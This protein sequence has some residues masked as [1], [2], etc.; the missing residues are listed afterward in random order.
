M[1]DFMISQIQD[2]SGIGLFCLIAVFFY[3]GLITIGGGQVAITVMQ[4]VLV[5]QFHLIDD[6]FFFNMVAISESTP[7]PIGIN[8]ATY[9]GTELYGVWGGFFSTLGEVL[10]SLICIV[11]I[12]KF[13]G[14][15]AEKKGVKA[16][17]STLRPAVSGVI[18][19][20]AARIIIIALFVVREGFLLSS[21]STWN[22][23]L[24]IYG[25]SAIFYCLCLSVLF[26]TK[27]HPVF[28]VAAGALFGAIF[29]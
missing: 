23:N 26:R 12:A 7:G 11:L 4:Q 18:A 10:P 16:A 5:D 2:Q 17:F 22:E 14:S 6:A 20:A 3:V 24:Q 13:F 19:V 29:C 28:L 27:I 15:F 25:V 21:P 8:I 1:I 9:I